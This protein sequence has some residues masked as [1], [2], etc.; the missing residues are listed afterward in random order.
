MALI[1]VCVRVA[2]R[3]D[4]PRVRKT[5]GR[6]RHAADGNIR[7]MLTAAAALLTALLF[8]GMTLFAFGFAAVLFTTL[9]PESARAVIRAAF[10]WFY[11]FVIGAAAAAAVLWWPISTSAALIL[12]IIALS[13]WPTRQL[14]MPAINRATDAGDKARFKALHGASVLI[15][16][17]HIGGSGWVL[18]QAV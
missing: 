18:V 16:L 11:L 14:L 4:A 15:T 6:Q 3:P 2:T 17:A 7:A 13:T 5:P 9:P 1:E 12:A 8:G 10:P